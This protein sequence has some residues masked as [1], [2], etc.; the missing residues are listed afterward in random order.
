MENKPQNISELF[1]IIENKFDSLKNDIET[2]KE[3]ISQ[4]QSDIDTYVIDNEHKE[5]FLIIFFGN[6]FNNEPRIYLDKSVY[7]SI[8]NSNNKYCIKFN[9][10]FDVLHKQKNIDLDLISNF[11]VSPIIYKIINNYIDLFNRNYDSVN[12]IFDAEDI[13]FSFIFNNQCYVVKLN[14]NNVIKCYID[15]EYK[16]EKINLL[17]F[18]KYLKQ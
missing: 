16:Q 9:N 11:N 15:N 10:L 6:V 5:R 17:K 3:L 2:L 8:R 18:E 4:S 13:G 14:D 12:I 1:K 7:E